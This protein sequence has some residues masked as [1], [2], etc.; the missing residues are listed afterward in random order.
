M[1]LFRGRSWKYMEI[2]PDLIV[3]RTTCFV[4][5]ELL[6]LLVPRFMRFGLYPCLV[7]ASTCN[8]LILEVP[9]YI[10]WHFVS[11]FL[12]VMSNP[13]PQ[14]P[15]KLPR[16]VKWGIK[17]V[18]SKT[19]LNSNGSTLDQQSTDVNSL[20]KCSSLV[21]GSQQSSGPL[22][23]SKTLFK[24]LRALQLWICRK[25]HLRMPAVSHFYQHSPWM[26]LLHISWAFLAN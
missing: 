5:T 24:L 16:L 19:N 15:Q 18:S 14:M 11:E 4:Y 13:N 21:E 17:R 9:S 10:K 12:L 1:I 8:R 3:K 23:L 20:P 25:T 6:Q 7:K 26:C 22:Q 2:R